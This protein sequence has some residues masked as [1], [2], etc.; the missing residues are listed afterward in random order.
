[1]KISTRELYILVIIRDANRRA[2]SALDYYTVASSSRRAMHPIMYRR[3]R[4]A[5]IFTIPVIA[6]GMWSWSVLKLRRKPPQDVR[7]AVGSAGNYVLFICMFSR[8]CCCLTP[9]LTGSMASSC[10]VRAIRSWDGRIV[11]STHILHST[12]VKKSV[13]VNRFEI[14]MSPRLIATTGCW[15]DAGGIV[16]LLF[17]NTSWLSPRVR[18]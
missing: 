3:A 13:T 15:P 4:R 8:S 11:S 10:A 18:A 14:P 6:M 12:T 17:S 2:L 7:F 5:T 9:W 1:M 16:L